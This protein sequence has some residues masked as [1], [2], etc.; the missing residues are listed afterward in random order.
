MGPK[1]RILEICCAPRNKSMLI[2]DHNKDVK[3]TGVEISVNRANI[4]KNL[5][6]KYHLENQIEVITEDGLTYDNKELFDRVLVDAECTHEGSIKHIF[7][8]FK[9][10]VNPEGEMKHNKKLT[11]QQEKQ[12]KANNSNPYTSDITKTNKWTK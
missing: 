1:N 2:A 4:M 12:F 7:K 9:E 5:L 3:I 8:F 6:K 10:E 11:K